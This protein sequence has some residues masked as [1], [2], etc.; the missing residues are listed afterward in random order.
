MRYSSAGVH[1]ADQVVC[2]VFLKSEAI[3]LSQE[4]SFAM[5]GGA[6]KQVFSNKKLHL[7]ESSDLQEKLGQI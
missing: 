1:C 7:S 4:L 6:S 2:I 3:N 5:A